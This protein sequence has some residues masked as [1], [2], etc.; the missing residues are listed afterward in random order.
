MG[1]HMAKA[2]MAL[3][4]MAWLLSGCASKKVVIKADTCAELQVHGTIIKGYSV[5]ERE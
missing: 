4:C 5:C 3:F 1:D 2:I